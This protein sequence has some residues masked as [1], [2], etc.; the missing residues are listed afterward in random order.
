MQNEV[1]NEVTD[2][3]RQIQPPDL[4]K[5]FDERQV[6][7]PPA[8]VPTPTPSPDPKPA[9]PFSQVETPPEPP[10]TPEA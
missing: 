5:A 7:G 2:V 1:Q 10:S 4:R 3:V 9:S 6:F 8:P